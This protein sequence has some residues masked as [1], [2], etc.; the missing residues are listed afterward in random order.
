MKSHY[1]TYHRAAWQYIML[2]AV[3]NIFV[4]I[5]FSVTL[6]GTGIITLFGTG[7]AKNRLLEGNKKS[8]RSLRAE[9]NIKDMGSTGRGTSFLS[10][11]MSLNL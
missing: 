11:L 9:G 3:K 4:K 5:L 1:K 10:D 8:L 6:I 7:R 2:C